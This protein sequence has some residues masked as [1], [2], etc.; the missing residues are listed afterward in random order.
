MI[1]DEFIKQQKEKK[2]SNKELKA[3]REKGERVFYTTQITK[4]TEIRKVLNFSAFIVLA[5][6]LAVT[7]L[8]VVGLLS[9]G[10]SGSVLVPLIVTIAFY[11]AII[12]WFTVFLPSIKKKLKNYVLELEKIR[13]KDVQKQRNIYKN[14]LKWGIYERIKKRNGVRWRQRFY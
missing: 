3:I 9:G 4:L 10:F 8:L 2:L 14:Y 5:M 12:L 7:V 1:R 6:L 11:L 13:E